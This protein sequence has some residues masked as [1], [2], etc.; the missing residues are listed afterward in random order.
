MRL[1]CSTRWTARPSGDWTTVNERK[2]KNE[3]RR[4]GRRTEEERKTKNG[5]RT[6]EERKTKN[7]RRAEEELKKNGRRTEE[8][9]ENARTRER[10][11]EL[12]N[13]RNKE[14]GRRAAD[15]RGL[16]ELDDLDH[17]VAEPESE[18][19]QRRALEAAARGR[20]D[21]ERP[22]ADLM[23][24]RLQRREERRE[25]DAVEDRRHDLQH[26]SRE[27]INAVD[28]TVSGSGVASRNQS[29]ASERMPSQRRE[30]IGCRVEHHHSGKGRNRPGRGRREDRRPTRLTGRISRARLRHFFDC[31]V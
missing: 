15:A 31:S 20:L 19:Q 28:T 10:T 22:R 6:E 26:E 24:V 14:T 30:R 21:R 17:H 9:R 11:N 12:K 23:E 3:R 5:R 16:D 27:R 4:S 29:D 7:G 1:S 8:E 2:T 18:Q 13:G 25:E